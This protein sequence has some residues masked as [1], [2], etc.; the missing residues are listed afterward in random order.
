MSKR[1]LSKL[2]TWLVVGVI[3]GFLMVVAVGMIYPPV[4]TNTGAKIVC[5]GQV[6]Q[7]SETY[8]PV[9]GETTTT[10]E[11]YCRDESGEQR[12]ITWLAIGASFLFF[13]VASGMFMFL[14]G[15][16]TA[17]LRSTGKDTAVPVPVAVGRSEDMQAATSDLSVDAPV[18]HGSTQ[19]DSS[20]GTAGTTTATKP[21][22]DYSE[23]RYPDS[24]FSRSRFPDGVRTTAKGDVEEAEGDVEHLA[25]LDRLRRDGSLTEEEFEILKRRIIGEG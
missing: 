3:V 4:I 10:R 11:W 2:T 22:F 20:A 17:P 7:E 15:R 8:R 14:L 1:L 12:D 23:P 18:S 6:T 21:A 13:T 9:P 16:V 24:E 25:E 5:S 19:D